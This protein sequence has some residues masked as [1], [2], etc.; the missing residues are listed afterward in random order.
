M[1]KIIEIMDKTVEKARKC[2]LCGNE[3]LS[4]WPGERVCKRCRSS[5]VWRQG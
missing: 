1:A 4:S 2:L 3:F 5:S